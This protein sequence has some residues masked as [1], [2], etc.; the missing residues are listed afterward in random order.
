MHNIAQL[1]N[2]YMPIC[3]KDF[4][5]HHTRELIE[6]AGESTTWDKNIKYNM[7]ATKENISGGKC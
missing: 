4:Q 1:L 7:G 6:Q 3:L 5:P 2:T